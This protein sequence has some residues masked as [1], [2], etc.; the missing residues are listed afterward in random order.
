[1]ARLPA[2]HYRSSE[3]RLLPVRHWLAAIRTESIKRELTMRAIVRAA[4]VLALA[5]IGST[6]A[7]AYGSPPP[8]ATP[9][10]STFIL[11][12]IG[13]AAIGFTISRSRRNKR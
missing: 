1:M 6:C 7:L 3:V 10:P 9:E 8:L 5:L 11:V 2:P 13:L 4:A 12:G